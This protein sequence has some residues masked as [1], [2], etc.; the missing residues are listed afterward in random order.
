MGKFIRISH[1]R[2]LIIFP[3]LVALATLLALLVIQ[4]P[5]FGTDGGIT[6]KKALDPHIFIIFTVLA[7]TLS[8]A[9]VDFAFW[10]IDWCHKQ[11]A[12]GWCRK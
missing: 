7:I 2:A 5:A 3:L 4:E 12:I 11:D 8:L 9:L 10:L 6:F 1:K